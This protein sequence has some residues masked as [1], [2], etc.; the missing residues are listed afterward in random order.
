MAQDQEKDS[1][2]PATHGAEMDRAPR[3]SVARLEGLDAAGAA[4]EARPRADAAGGS[5]ARCRGIA[6]Q[7][8]SQNLLIFTILRLISAAR[9]WSLMTCAAC[10]P[11]S[12][13]VTR[14]SVAS[15]RVSS[16]T[17]AWPTT[18]SFIEPRQSCI[19]ARAGRIW[20]CRRGNSVRKNPAARAPSWR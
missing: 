13:S 17:S 15:L 2:R 4:A 18:A 16:S 6:A 12:M 3:P 1:A 9:G 5:L 10:Q 20:A 7:A 11:A 19:S 14:P 8:A